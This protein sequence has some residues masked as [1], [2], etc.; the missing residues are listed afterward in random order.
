MLPIRKQRRY[1]VRA[2]IAT[3]GSS[4]FVVG[5]IGDT[6]RKAGIDITNIAVGRVLL[7]LQK[8]KEI[9]VAVQ[10]GGNVA[11]QYEAVVEPPA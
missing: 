1:T 10:G 2:A 4:R 11:N 9:K 8:R 6:L 5:Q 3:H 7:R